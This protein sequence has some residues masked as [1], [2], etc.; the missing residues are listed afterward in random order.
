MTSRAAERLRD[1]DFQDR[2]QKPPMLSSW[3]CVST[4]STTAV[5][6]PLFNILAGL[7]FVRL[8]SGK[9]THNQLVSAVMKD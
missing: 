7:L 5:G 2:A 4:I 8:P 6:L 1:V 3:K 9:A